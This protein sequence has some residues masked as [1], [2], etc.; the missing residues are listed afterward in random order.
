[1]RILFVNNIPFNP[2]YGGIERVTDILA[3]E[4]K[5][6]GY[7]VFYLCDYVEDKQILEYDFPAQLFI[8]PNIGYF[9]SKENIV[10]YSDLLKNLNVDVVVNQ[11]GVNPW[12]NEILMHGTKC[13]SVFHSMPN[14]IL[15]FE[16]RSVL[17]YPQKG[18][19]YIKFIKYLIKVALYPF[20]CIKTKRIVSA[21]LSRQIAFVEE[22]SDAVVLLSSN[23]IN[24]LS[25]YLPIIDTT[26]IRSI[27]NPNTYPQQQ[28]NWD[29]KENLILYVGRLDGYE[30]FPMRLL[31]IW[32]RLYLRHP[33][34]RLVF[35]GDGSERFP[36]QKFIEKNRLERAFLVGRKKN[37]A[38]YYRKASFICLTS[39]SEGWGM[40]LTE[41]MQFGCIPF[42][43]N[44]YGAAFDIIDDG[45]NGHL[46]PAYN[47][48][49]YAKRLSD[50]MFDEK[51]RR[52]IAI[53]AHK[54]SMHF[55]VEKV[56]EQ[57]DELFHTIMNV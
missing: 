25:L 39:S 41:G 8:L 28:I 13:V 54:K 2:A 57:W 6:R 29:C 18:S 55:N 38:E 53:A 49:I 11:R 56:V 46:I 10:F 24:D 19:K 27:P 34:W 44:N 23:N 35:V 4:L 50:L 1:M 26:K 12:Q 36:M 30:K 7:Q 47:L 31:E 16:L 22:H 37:V 20:L 15:R 5:E 3:K 17:S 33:D 42:T 51:K 9:Q 48:R 45:V 21:E 32:K 14:G 43:F 40:A 52:G